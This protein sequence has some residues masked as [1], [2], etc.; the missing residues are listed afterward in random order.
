MDTEAPAENTTPS[1]DDSELL[2]ADDDRESRPAFFELSPASWFAAFLGL[3]LRTIWAL[4]VKNTG[5][6]ANYGRNAA[7]I[8]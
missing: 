2:P 4:L 8:S 3:V 5:Y 7:T 6:V 1:C